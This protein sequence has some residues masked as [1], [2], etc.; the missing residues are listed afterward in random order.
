LYT[1]PLK[2]SIGGAAVPT[3]KM[4]DV[5]KRGQIIARPEGLGALLHASVNGTIAEISDTYIAI[6]ASPDQSGGH[7]PIPASDNIVET[8]KD[9]GLIGMGGAGF[10]THIK[11]NTDLAGGVVIINAAECEPLLQHN[12]AQIVRQPEKVYRGLLLSMQ[13]TKA[14]RGILAIKAKNAEA[15][16]SFRNVIPAGGNVE[17]AELRD[18]YPMG[19]ERA[20]IRDVLGMTLGVDQLPSV[21]GAVILN[22]ETIARVAEAVDERKPVISKH[23]TIAGLL[24][25]GKESRVFLDVPIGTPISR[26]IDECGGI[27]GHAGEIVMGGPFT[28]SSTAMDAPVVKTTGGII[29]SMEFPGEKRPLGLLVCACGGSE[30]RMREIAGHM[31]AAVVSVRK[32]KQAKEVR[33]ALKCENPGECPG[34]A[35][36]ILEMRKEGAEALLVGS[37]SDCSN[38]VMGVAPKLKMGVHHQTDTIMRTLGKPLVRR[39]PL[40]ET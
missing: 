34:Q 39:L 14:A 23:L 24:K 13:V 9:A 40:S 8:V 4:G 17:I 22:V 35:E 31:N 6:A 32:C 18:L 10:P 7:Q 36:K 27:D 37:C 33:G 26:L 12:I 30:E 29:V 15:I 2:Q 20:I 25:G 16:R 28:G 3:V 5:V 1:L 38:T 21:A 19:E 11:L